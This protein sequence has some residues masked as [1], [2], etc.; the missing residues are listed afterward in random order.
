MCSSRGDGP[1]PDS[2]ALN[3]L[4]VAAWPVGGA[5]LPPQ[6]QRATMGCV[7]PQW[8]NVV[9]LRCLIC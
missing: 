4:L 1:T 7:D 6:P 2:V 9:L 3:P 5:A 8:A